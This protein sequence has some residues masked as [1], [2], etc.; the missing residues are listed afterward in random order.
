MKIELLLALIMA[1]CAFVSLVA[2]NPAQA[3][4]QQRDAAFYS[5]IAPAAGLPDQAMRLDR[6]QIRNVQH[7][8]ERHG[9]QPGQLD[10]IMGP[11]T[12][13]AL[14]SFQSDNNLP[15]TGMATNETLIRLGFVARESRNNNMR[16]NEPVMRGQEMM[17]ER[18]DYDMR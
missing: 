18:R 14:R 8:L 2:I 17:P 11:R 4:Q 1:T 9:Y 15:I 5:S 12:A 3:Q 16:M 10:G 13:R 6:T 7:A